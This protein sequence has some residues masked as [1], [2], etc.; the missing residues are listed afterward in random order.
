[1]PINAQEQ[2]LDDQQILKLYDGLRVADVADGMDIAG[3]RNV[4]LMDTRV[5]ALWKDLDEFDHQIRGIAITARYVPHN[6]VLPN[7]MPP[8]KFTEWEGNWYWKISPER[9]ST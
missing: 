5:Q 8:E 3:L 6:L 1:L 2:P 4:G 7:P 9:S